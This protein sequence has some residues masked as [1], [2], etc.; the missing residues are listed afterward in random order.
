MR[1][2][3]ED[4]VPGHAQIPDYGAQGPEQQVGTVS[5]VVL[6]TAGFMAF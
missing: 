2:R 3:W 4:E 1:W 6:I 5:V